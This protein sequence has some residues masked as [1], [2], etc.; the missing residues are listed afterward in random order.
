MHGDL[1]AEQLLVGRNKLALLDWDRARNGDPESDLASFLARQRVR[2]IDADSAVAWQ[3][4][5]AHLLRGY[6]QTGQ[7]VMQRLNLH[8][9]LE[10]IKAAV[11]P[12]RHRDPQWP[13]KINVLLD[14]AATIANKLA[15]TTV[16]STALPDSAEFAASQPPDELV[17]AQG[18]WL[19]PALDSAMVGAAISTT[20]PSAATARIQQVRIL[21]LKP[22]QRALIQYK[23]SITGQ[24]SASLFG[25]VRAAGVDVYSADVQARLFD[26]VGEK[27]SLLFRVARPWGIIPELNLWLQEPLIGEQAVRRLVPN[28][29]PDGTRMIAQALA[30]LHRQPIVVTRQHTH[31]DELSILHEC[32]SKVAEARPS[33]ADKVLSVLHDCQR[34]LPHYPP[35]KHCAVHRDFY[36]AQVIFLAGDKVAFVDFDLFAMSDPLIDV[37]NF[38]AHLRESAIRKHGD[39]GALAL[40]EHAFVEGYLSAAPWAGPQAIE[41][42]ML[43]SLARQIYISWANPERAQ[44]TSAILAECLRLS[45]QINST[46]KS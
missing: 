12:F 28:T 4:V 18:D 27:P 7:L 31:A 42:H 43:V 26:L 5:L 36:P 32:L 38:V 35:L 20:I 46:V 24:Q 19:Q 10:L 29:N 17:E 33:E 1:H 3:N 11:L 14:L 22:G 15:Q 2:M 8:L 37:G 41:A 40:H 25:K 39:P 16:G 45:G 30:E 6:R 9:L 44:A 34:S 23:L 21:Q 13:D